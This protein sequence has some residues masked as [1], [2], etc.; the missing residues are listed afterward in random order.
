MSLTLTE[1]KESNTVSNRPAHTPRH[2][3]PCSLIAHSSNLFLP[4]AQAV[5]TRAY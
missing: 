2:G 1:P 5:A 3:A 4:A